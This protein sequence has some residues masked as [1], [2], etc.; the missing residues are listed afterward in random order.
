MPLD[1]GGRI[2]DDLGQSEVQ[3]LYPAIRQQLEV[4]RLQ[5]TVNDSSLVSRFQGLGGLLTDL[6]GFIDRQRATLQSIRQILAFDQLEDKRLGIA[7]LLQTMYP[8]NV[9]MI[10]CSQ[11]FGFS[12]ESRQPFRGLCEGFRQHLD[13]HLPVQL[14]VRS[15]IHLAH[16]TL[17]QFGGH[18]VVGD[19]L[20]NHGASIHV[21]GTP[22]VNRFLCLKS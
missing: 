18:A 7:T 16:T 20:P 14:R 3:H 21:S 11:S 1:G 9:G 19:G 12:L 4:T 13:G 10:E 8:G 2:G 15:P 5:V 6:Q 17:A 22:P